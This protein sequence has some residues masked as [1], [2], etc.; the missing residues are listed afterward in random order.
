MKNLTIKCVKGQKVGD[1]LL[2]LEDGSLQP[3]FPETFYNR[4][5]MGYWML[6]QLG[7]KWKVEKFILA[8][9]DKCE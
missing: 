1:S 4:N 2:E 8:K 9:K 7:Y 3:I 5:I 6:K